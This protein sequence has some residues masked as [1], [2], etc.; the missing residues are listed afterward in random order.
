MWVNLV[1][2]VYRKK[3]KIDFLVFDENFRLVV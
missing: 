3:S 1:H 2:T